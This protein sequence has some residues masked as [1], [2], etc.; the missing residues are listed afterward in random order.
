MA[1]KHIVIAVDGYS[2]CG[3]STLSRAISRKLNIRY[4]D[5]GAMYRAI[6][7]YF[8]ENNVPVPSGTGKH[9][10]N[11]MYQD[12]LDNIDLRLNRNPVSGAGELHLNGRNVEKEIRRPVVSE[13][14]SHVSS[15][16]EVRNK[17]VGILQAMRN[18]DSLIM[19]GRDIGTTVFPEANLKIFMTADPMVRAKRRFDELTKKGVNVTFEEVM[20]NLNER[21][22]ED[23]HRAISPLRRAADAVVLDNTLL[24][25]A[26]Q[27]AFALNEIEKLRKENLPS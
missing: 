12:V 9:M 2:S 23:S 19:D 3:K 17:I 22:H 21:D 24:S 15:I 18:E 26:D 11:F 10:N 20:K 8:L 16:G 4:V 14:V 6:T 13:Q 1:G 5:S 25:E 7:H 27:V